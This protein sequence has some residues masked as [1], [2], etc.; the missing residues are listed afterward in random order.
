MLQESPLAV[1]SGVSFRD[2]G[3]TLDFHFRCYCSRLGGMD[4]YSSRCMR[5]QFIVG[6]VSPNNV[7]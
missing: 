3:V 4:P 6:L 7:P 5:Q 1:K 2:C